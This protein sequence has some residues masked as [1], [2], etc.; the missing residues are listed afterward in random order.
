MRIAV[1][2]TVNLGVNLGANLQIRGALEDTITQ[3][4]L[5]QNSEYANYVPSDAQRVHVL[6]YDFGDPDWFPVGVKHKY[7]RAQ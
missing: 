3:E 2:V 4:L 6:L 1:T 5:H 7:T